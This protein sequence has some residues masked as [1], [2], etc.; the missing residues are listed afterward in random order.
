[1]VGLETKW[2]C[3]YLDLE[4]MYYLVEL[5]D[6]DGIMGEH[7]FETEEELDIY[8]KNNNIKIDK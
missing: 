1:M 6:E 7:F 8:I 3:Q 5:H 2:L 4:N